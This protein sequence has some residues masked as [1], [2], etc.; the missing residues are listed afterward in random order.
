[1]MVF[2]AQFKTRRGLHRV[3]FPGGPA[4]LPLHFVA[5]LETWRAFLENQAKPKTV[6]TLP[7][8]VEG[9]LPR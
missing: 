1:M 5:H 8:A 4:I 2:K 6:R 7:S 9:P 3:Q